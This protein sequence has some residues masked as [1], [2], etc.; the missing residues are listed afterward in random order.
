[1]K[2]GACADRVLITGG[3][4]FL[5]SHLCERLVE[6]G[7]HVL[8]VDNFA[9]GSRKNVAHLIGRPN[10]ELMKHDI[11]LPLSVP[12]A[13]VCNLACPASPIHYQKDPVQTNKT[14]VYG[15]LNMLELS[16]RTGAWCPT[17][18]FRR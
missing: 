6:S 2:D 15:S 16:L 11:T 18:L 17:S 13:F 3:T 10:F 9:T 1:M 12:A 4:G 8:C 5:G 14:N 7:R